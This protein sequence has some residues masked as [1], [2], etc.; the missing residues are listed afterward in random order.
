MVTWMATQRGSLL[1]GDLGDLGAL[2]HS[3]NHIHV[4]CMAKHRVNTIQV[5][6]GF[7]AK[8]ELGS[9]GVLAGVGHGER[10]GLVLIGVDLTVDLIPG[11]TGTSHARGT[12]ATVGATALGHKTIN[13]AVEG[14]TVIEARFRQLDEIGHCAWCIS[15]KEFNLD[16]AD[17]GIHEG[18]GH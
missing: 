15:I 18:F 14:Q 12:V 5:G 8:K 10:A 17:F 13:H 2:L 9:P 6:L 7:M 1:N 11:P 16:G 3:K 4:A